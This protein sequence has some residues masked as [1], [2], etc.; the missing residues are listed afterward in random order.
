MKKWKKNKGQPLKISTKTL[1]KIIHKMLQFH[2]PSIIFAKKIITASAQ[3]LKKR[4][5]T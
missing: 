5:I 1:K 3:V 4:T 2:F